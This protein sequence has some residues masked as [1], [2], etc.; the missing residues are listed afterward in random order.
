MSL[1][2]LLTYS[3]FFETVLAQLRDRQ[4]QD[5]YKFQ[6][7]Q[8]AR[9]FKDYKFGRR[10]RGGRDRAWQD[11]LSDARAGSDDTS[12]D[13]LFGI[14]GDNVDKLR[15]AGGSHLIYAVAIHY[16]LHGYETDEDL[17]FAKQLDNFVFDEITIRQ[18]GGVFERQSCST[19]IETPSHCLASVHADAL[20]RY[21]EEL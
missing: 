9:E 17:A 19:S 8:V 16:R 21:C 18:R 12:W 10:V 14:T 6:V 7:G 1:V 20:L 4:S 3:E 11:W 5:D 15:N 2:P 13:E